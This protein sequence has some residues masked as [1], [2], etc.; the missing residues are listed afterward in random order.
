MNEEGRIIG[1]ICLDGGKEKRIRTRKAVI[2]CSG[3]WTN[4][5]VMIPRHMNE[6]PETP[7][8][9]GET[10]A[11]LGM[12]YGPFTGEAIRAAQKAGA[13]VRHMEY[14]VSEPCYS[15]SDL[16]SQ[17]V[18]VAGITR[19]VGQ[20]MV[21]SNG[22]RFTDEGKTRGAIARDV[23]K[24][25]DN[26]FYPVLDGHFVPTQ[27]NPKEEVL[28]KWI[29]GGFV[30]T[31]DTLEEVASKAESS[32]G[33]PAITL[34]ASI[35]AYNEG[36]SSGTDEFGKDPHFLT[37]I[38]QAPFYVG[39]VETCIM[40]YTNGGLDADENARVRN[41]DGDVIP[42]LYAAGMCTGGQFGIDTVSGSWQTNSIVFGR[43][44][45][46]NASKETAE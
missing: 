31:A 27:V 21:G 18:A 33:I 22:K 28:Q 2:I 44:A 7:A 38:N 26:V 37:P 5:E 17:G 15:T 11:S 42:G 35:Q 4:D 25:E 16:M 6:L 34:I 3:P 39:P 13:A 1:A 14:C 12:P 43:I 24:L 20:V 23:L 8:A 36:C 46:A 9:A 30:V 32:F 29:D 40:L 19:V 41:A 10:F 45:G